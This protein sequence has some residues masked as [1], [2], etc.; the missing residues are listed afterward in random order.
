MLQL[1]LSHAG[2]VAA[3]AAA[4]H[5]RYVRRARLGS[6]FEGDRGCSLAEMPFLSV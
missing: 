3:A 5:D 2:G 4:V 6:E 1:G